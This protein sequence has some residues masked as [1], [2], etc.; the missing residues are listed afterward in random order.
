[1]GFEDY[2]VLICPEKHSPLWADNDMATLERIAVDIQIRWP[3]FH[4][5]DVAVA[6]LQYPPRPEEAF[7][8]YDTPA[9]LFQMLIMLN[10][11]ENNCVTIS[12]RF[13]YCNPRSV[14]EPFCAV[15]EWLMR[16]Y[17]MY[18]SV[19]RDLAPGQEGVSDEITDAGA[20]CAVLVPSMDYNRRLWQLDA[21]T[22]EEAVL[23]PGEAIARFVAP[24]YVSNGQ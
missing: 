10:R 5:D 3:E 11:R 19:M 7:L 17:A 15:I 4:T 6:H 9:G 1:M 14:Y 12:L 16:R 24:R 23:R 18:C 8:I 20:V 2:Q 13:A 21:G 22:E